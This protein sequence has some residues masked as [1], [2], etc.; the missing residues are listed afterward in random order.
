MSIRPKFS[1]LAIF[2]SVVVWSAVNA[3]RFGGRRSGLS[4]LNCFA[5]SGM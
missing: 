5:K 2:P 3:S 1:F 4:L